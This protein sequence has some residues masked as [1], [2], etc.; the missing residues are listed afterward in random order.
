MYGADDQSSPFLVDVLFISCTHSFSSS[1]AATFEGS[2][3]EFLSFLESPLSGTQARLPMQ[4][5]LAASLLIR[6]AMYST[7]TLYVADEIEAC[8]AEIEDLTGSL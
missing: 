4:F 2:F 7:E 3:V 8:A 1:D 5:Q 6:A